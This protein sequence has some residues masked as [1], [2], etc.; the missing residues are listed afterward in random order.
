MSCLGVTIASFRSNGV[1]PHQK[2][3][4]SVISGPL[5]QRFRLPKHRA[6]IGE[7][8][9][10]WY[11]LG[12]RSHETMVCMVPRRDSGFQTEIANA[13]YRINVPTNTTGQAVQTRDPER[14]PL[15]DEEHWLIRQAIKEK[16]GP[17]L[18]RVCVMLMLEFGA[19]P[20][21]II[22]LDEQDYRVLRGAQGQ[23]FCSVEVSRLKQRQ[24]VPEKR[25]RRISPDL[26]EALDELIQENH[27]RYGNSGPTAYFSECVCTNQRHTTY[28]QLGVLI[29][30]QEL[31]AK[32]GSHLSSYR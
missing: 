12:I 26:G 23:R 18:E 27:S 29:S 24:L 1:F 16:K 4:E 9:P 8:S 22:L 31:L 25:R 5:S 2:M 28:D 11:C 13:L 19:R 14:G 20:G 15:N 17:L 30:R 10:D 7:P 6:S 3:C 32:G 21:Q